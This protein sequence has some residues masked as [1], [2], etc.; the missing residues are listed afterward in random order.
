MAKKQET[1]KKN[2]EIQRYEEPQ[3]SMLPDFS[4]SGLDQTYKM[5]KYVASS[6]MVPPVYNNAPD[7]VLVAAELGARH[8]WSIVQS[9]QAIMVLKGK[10]T[11]WGDYLASLID[12]CKDLEYWKEGI[13]A[14]QHIINEEKDVAESLLGKY[15][16]EWQPDKYQICIIK[17]EGRDPVITI[18]DINRAE[19]EHKGKDSIHKFRSH[20]ERNLLRTARRHCAQDAM[21]ATLAGF[22]DIADESEKEKIME[23]VSNQPDPSMDKAQGEFKAEDIFDNANKDVSDAEIAEDAS[24]DKPQVE[25]SDSSAEQSEEDEKKETVGQD[26]APENVDTATGEIFSDDIFDEETEKTPV[27]NEK[28]SSDGESGKPKD[29]KTAKKPEPEDEKKSGTE[30]EPEPAEKSEAEQE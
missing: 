2:T 8:G 3:R 20:P 26:D 12:S 25:E 13:K 1:E 29:T 28:E 24:K 23:E 10:A 17:R 16:M 27:A 15:D 4:R 18:Y 22:D 7:R 5:A 9:C 19:R 30:P 6:G 11:I 21:P 14:Y